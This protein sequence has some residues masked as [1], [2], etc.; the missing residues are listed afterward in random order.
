MN[1]PNIGERNLGTS[2]QQMTPSVHPL[3]GPRL[4][5]CVHAVLSHPDQTA[6]DMLVEVDAMKLRSC[7]TL[8]TAVAPHEPA[9]GGAAETFY[10]GRPD[11]ETLC[12][13]G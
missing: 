5:V 13:L 4:I 8:F 2:L 6:V 12:L 9:F 1:P 3:L 10:D 7:L 11:A